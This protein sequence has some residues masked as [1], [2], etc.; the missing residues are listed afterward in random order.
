MH[1]FTYFYFG[2]LQIE[3]D[4]CEDLDLEST[5]FK[6]IACGEYVFSM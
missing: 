5:K 4:A 1:V 6:V 2:A 3:Q